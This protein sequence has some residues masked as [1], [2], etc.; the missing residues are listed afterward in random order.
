MREVVRISVGCYKATN[1]DI[2]SLNDEESE[3]QRGFLSYSS[4]Q[5]G[6]RI[7]SENQYDLRMVGFGHR[8]SWMYI[9]H[10]ERKT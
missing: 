4:P 1:L 5:G 9:S 6:N 8:S 7:H 10:M 2:I 3:A